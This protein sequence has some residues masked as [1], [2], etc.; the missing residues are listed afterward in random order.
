MAEVAIGSIIYAPLIPDYDIHHVIFTEKRVLGI[1]ISKLTS[2]AQ[3]GAALGALGLFLAGANPFTA[4]GV[5]G[6]IGMGVWKDIKK[7]GQGNSFVRIESGSDVTPELESLA[8]IKME[9]DKIKEISV[10]KM[11]GAEDYLLKIGKGYFSSWSWAIRPEALTD[12]RSLISKTSLAP[13][14]KE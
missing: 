8:S 2:A 9:N 11:W 6:L 7:H 1:P 3:K 5:S 12:V 10:K 4:Y 13:V 14:L